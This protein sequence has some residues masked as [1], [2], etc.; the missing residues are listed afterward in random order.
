MFVCLLTGK[1]FP[2]LNKNKLDVAFN[3]MFVFRETFACFVTIALY[4]WPSITS[5]TKTC[6]KMKLFALLGPV[7]I[8]YNFFTVFYLIGK[9]VN[10][11]RLPCDG[12]PN[13]TSRTRWT[14]HGPVRR[15]WARLWFRR[16]CGEL[17]LQFN[18]QLQRR[19]QCQFGC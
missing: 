19:L 5:L 18:C 7:K 9:S 6:G 17:K 16:Q 8:K 15:L 3:K 13:G 14:Q 2:P 4:K 11:Y 1:Q 10:Y 12:R